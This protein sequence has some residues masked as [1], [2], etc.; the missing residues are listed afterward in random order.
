MCGPDARRQ[1][2]MSNVATA[3]WSFLKF[4]ANHTTVSAKVV[5]AQ[6]DWKDMA[7]TVR[8][9]KFTLLVAW[10]THASS[11]FSTSRTAQDYA[12]RAAAWLEELGLAVIYNKDMA[13]LLKKLRFYRTLDDSTRKPRRR[14]RKGFTPKQLKYLNETTRKW[15]KEK[16][17]INQKF[18]MNHR[19]AANLCARRS[20]MYASLYRPGEAGGLKGRFIPLRCLSRK[21]LTVGKNGRTRVKPG[22]LKNSYNNPMARMDMEMGS[23]KAESK[24]PRYWSSHPAESLQGLMATDPAGPDE[25]LFRDARLHTMSGPLPAPLLTQIDR[26]IIEEC[27]DENLFDQSDVFAYTGYS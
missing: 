16:R 8:Q 3:L 25:P 17:K 23:F 12:N 26:M 13:K 4:W 2:T 10:L 21:K 9:K 11:N 20:F 5:A 27:S 18:T 19:M 24:R 15:A 22:D 14:I 1:G 6:G 7:P